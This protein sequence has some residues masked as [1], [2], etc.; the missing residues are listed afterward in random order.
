M[1]IF[2]KCTSE[3]DR[4]FFFFF[5]EGVIS[6]VS[7]FSKAC[8]QVVVKDTLPVLEMSFTFTLRTYL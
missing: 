3:P 1:T 4:F 8:T 7:S 6:V 5:C 2:L